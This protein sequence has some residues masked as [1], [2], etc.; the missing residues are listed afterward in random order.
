MDATSSPSP[1][2]Q[3]QLLGAFA[4]GSTWAGPF[5][6]VLSPRE[7]HL[8]DQ[9]LE[10]LVQDSPHV[11]HIGLDLASDQ[12]SSLHELL[13]AR[14][15]DVLGVDADPSGSSPQ[16]VIHMF[17]LETSLFPELL[18][19]EASLLPTLA[20]EAEALMGLPVRLVAW[21]DAS[22]LD[23]MAAQVP[24]LH[25]S[26]PP[27]VSFFEE[28]PAINPY[29][30]FASLHEKEQTIE[31]GAPKS[32]LW[33]EIGEA[34]AKAGKLSQATEY[35][36]ETVEYAES[37]QADESGSRA[38]LLLGDILM[39]EGD[40][41]HALEQYQEAE[42]LLPEGAPQADLHHRMGQIH[43]RLRHYKEALPF[44]QATITQAAAEGNQALQRQAYQ[45]LAVL[46]EQWGKP[47]QAVATYQ[48]LGDLVE[49][50]A[51]PAPELLAHT[52]QQMGAIHQGRLEWN[53]ALA[54]FQK[55]LTF[56]KETS[57]DFLIHALEDSV[58]DLQEKA[59]QPGPSGE[60]KKKGWLGRLFGS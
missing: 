15:A 47:N 54:A 11:Q 32:G 23:I 30:H 27:A 25:Q 6:P 41:S 48:K 2:P 24:E 1:D 13:N 26:L 18:K 56:A 12:V 40:S 14:L 5:L 37:E 20:A 33:L 43:L 4:P 7:P 34:L 52:Y 21:T 36:K 59:D 58:E 22:F 16:T 31:A 45:Q 50:Q 49:S 60:T 38:Y 8:R 53:D 10:Q 39:A 3:D 19:G 9:F 28:D 17:G 55:A 46:Y 42:D 35:L 51:E 57:D 29:E 44:F